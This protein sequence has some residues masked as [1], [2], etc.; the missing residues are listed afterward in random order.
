METSDLVAWSDNFHA[1]ILCLSNTEVI[2]SVGDRPKEPD[3][4]EQI[5]RVAILTLL[6]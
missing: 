1:T 3:D 5:I 6:G 2:T 4:T